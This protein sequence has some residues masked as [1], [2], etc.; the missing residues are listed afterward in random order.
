MEGTRKLYIDGLNHIEIGDILLSVIGINGIGTVYH[1]FE[2][3]KSTRIRF[4]YNVKVFIANDLKPLIVFNPNSGYY[5]LKDK[6]CIAFKWN[7]K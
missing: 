4:R 1:V 7:K 2:A 5:F 3:K 6:K